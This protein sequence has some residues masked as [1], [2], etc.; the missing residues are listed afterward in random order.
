MQ[1]IKMA[2]L[3]GFIVKSQYKVCQS[4]SA[5]EQHYKNIPIRIYWK[6]T[7]KKWKFSDK[8]KSDVFHISAQNIEIIKIMYTP[9]NPSFTI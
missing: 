2:P 7:T 6:F 3:Q 5:G 8:K 4:V 1:I 9:V